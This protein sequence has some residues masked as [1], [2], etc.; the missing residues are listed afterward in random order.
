MKISAKYRES[1]FRALHILAHVRLCTLCQ[2]VPTHSQALTAF[3]RGFCASMLYIFPRKEKAFEKCAYSQAR[4]AR[5][6][7]AYVGT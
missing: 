6:T 2:I 5:A 1:S 7:G 3:C 4:G